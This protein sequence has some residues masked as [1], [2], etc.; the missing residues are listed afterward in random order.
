MCISRGSLGRWNPYR[1]LDWGVLGASV[2]VLMVAE[3]CYQLSASLRFWDPGGVAQPI[4]RGLRGEEA[5]GVT[6]SG[7]GC[8]STWLPL[9]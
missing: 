2:H 1:Y 6:Q 8:L 5:S 4:P 9:V 3:K 7:G